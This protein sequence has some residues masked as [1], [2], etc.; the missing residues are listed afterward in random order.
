MSV[1]RLHHPCGLRK[2]SADCSSKTLHLA[3]QCFLG[4]GGGMI[5]CA[6]GDCTSLGLGGGG[7]STSN[8]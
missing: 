2:P 5:H 8:A 7:R 6:I 4:G 3:A 1:D